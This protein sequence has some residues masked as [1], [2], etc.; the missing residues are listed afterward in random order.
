MLKSRVFNLIF[1]ETTVAALTPLDFAV[2]IPLVLSLWEIPNRIVGIH[3]SDSTAFVTSSSEKNGPIEY[4]LLT[5]LTASSHSFSEC[6]VTPFF[7]TRWWTFCLNSMCRL[8]SSSR[9]KDSSASNFSH[10]PDTAT[11]PTI[12]RPAQSSSMY[13][14]SATPANSAI[15]SRRLMWKNSPICLSASL[16][17]LFFRNNF[18]IALSSCL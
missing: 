15:S 5:S 3:L 7:L 2:S 13:F 12:L 10:L 1:S 9:D 18:L 16:T 17:S 14:L 8:S 11:L 6:W 4:P